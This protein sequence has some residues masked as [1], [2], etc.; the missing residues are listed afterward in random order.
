MSLGRLT[1]QSVLSLLAISIK[2]GISQVARMGSEVRWK[3]KL[4]QVATP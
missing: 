3:A 2:I 4:H 1:M